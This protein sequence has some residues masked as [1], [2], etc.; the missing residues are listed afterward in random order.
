MRLSRIQLPPRVLRQVLTRPRTGGFDKAYPEFWINLREGMPPV[1]RDS[2][3][4]I[5]LRAKS[6]GEVEALHA[7]ALATAGASDSAPGIRPQD[8]VRYDA[9]FAADPDGN[10]IEA[11]TFPAEQ[12]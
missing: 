12:S 7:A 11:V 5:C 4:H 10:R 2:G 8:R 1:P 6:T 9:A 3:V